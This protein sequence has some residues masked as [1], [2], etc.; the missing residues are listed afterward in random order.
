MCNSLKCEERRE[1]GKVKKGQ[2][3]TK[4]RKKMRK[5]ERYEER[6][7]PYW[8][9][10]WHIMGHSKL[11]QDGFWLT[12]HNF[13]LSYFYS[14]WKTNQYFI[15]YWLFIKGTFSYQILWN[16]LVRVLSMIVTLDITYTFKTNSTFHW[17]VLF[18]WIIKT[19]NQSYVLWNKSYVEGKLL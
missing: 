11:S 10:Q 3:E 14:M 4:R 15:T 13:L 8:F 6:S 16:H 7:F 12:F 19:W 18:L 2:R 1:G 17:L 5:Q 9:L